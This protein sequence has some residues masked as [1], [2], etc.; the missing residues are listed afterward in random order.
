MNTPR[1]MPSMLAALLAALV[2]LAACTVDVRNEESGRRAEVDIRT[3]V[4]DLSVRTDVDPR[5]TGLRV[6]PG[7]RAARD[8]D[9][10][11]ARVSIGSSW[12]GLD[13]V[14]ANFQSTDA[15]ERVA[16]FYR[17]E[18]KTHG[19][20]IVCRGDVDFAKGRVIC[21]ED[22]SSRHVQ[23]AVGTEARHRIVDVKPSGSGSEFALVYI[24]T[25]GER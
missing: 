3:P 8:D 11:S 14:A 16:D 13:V 24:R 2:P 19:D 1:D 9:P 6:Y 5:D 23:L 21:R 20:V 12:F 18:M 15:P 25:Q 22:A 7:A 4:G 17:N 10:D